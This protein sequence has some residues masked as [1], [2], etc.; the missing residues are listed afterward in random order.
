MRW[1]FFLL[2]LNS[3]VVKTITDYQLRIINFVI[4]NQ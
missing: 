4:D 2:I 1:E 3:N